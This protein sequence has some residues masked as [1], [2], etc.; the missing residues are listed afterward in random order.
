LEFVVETLPREQLWAHVQP[1]S[2]VR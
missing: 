1:L 2:V